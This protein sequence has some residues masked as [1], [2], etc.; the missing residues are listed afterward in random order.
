[1]IKFDIYKCSF[2]YQE[3]IGKNNPRVK[4]RPVLIL[5]VD[6]F[7]IVAKITGTNHNTDK[8]YFI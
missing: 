6:D 2:I 5:S 8:C 1:M 4:D 3:D 7:V